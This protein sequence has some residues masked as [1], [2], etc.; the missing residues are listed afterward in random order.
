MSTKKGAHTQGTIVI[1]GRRVGKIARR[2]LLLDEQLKRERQCSP[3]VL[4]QRSW[5]QALV[6]IASTARVDEK[7]N[8]RLEKKCS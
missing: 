6:A 1:D 7:P 4:K 8:E 5:N 3:L 2:K